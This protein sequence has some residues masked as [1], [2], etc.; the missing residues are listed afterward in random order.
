M[1]PK[2]LLSISLGI[3]MALTLSAC[4]LPFVNTVRGSGNVITE[5]REVSDFDAI[6]LDGA[7]GLT[8]TQGE[9]TSLQIEAEDNIL[10]KLTSEVQEDKLVLGYEESFWKTTLF[11]THGIN[12]TLTVT[13]LSAITLNGAG[14][15]DLDALETDSL[16]VEVNGAGQVTITNLA[17]DSLSLE[18]NGTGNAHLSGDVI[19]QS[20]TIDGAGNVNA[21]DLR[22]AKA[23]IEVN[24]LGNGTIWVT[25]ALTVTVNGGGSLSYYGNPTLSQDISGAGNIVHLGEK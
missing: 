7:G 22:S 16:T 24:G 17:A 2:W 21:G 23:D 15:L 12:Y 25:E 10:P 18:I 14:S 8:I 19:N 3:I 11:P 20:I 6:R 13:D 5:T 4:T 9:N 1:K